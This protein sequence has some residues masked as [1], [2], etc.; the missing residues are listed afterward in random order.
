MKVLATAITAAL[1][2][3]L[4]LPSMGDAAQKK[5]ARAKVKARAVPA[6][7]LHY[8]QYSVPGS[9]TN[10]GTPCVR[11]TWEGCLGWDPDP[12]I[13]SMIDRDQNQDER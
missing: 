12:F 1:A 2:V 3:A 7:Q 10:A 11:Y 13:R 5:K 9:R 6:A 8:P 4:A